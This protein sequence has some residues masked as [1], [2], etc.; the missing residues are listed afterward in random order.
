MNTSKS[1]YCIFLLLVLTIA[2][3]PA[4]SF[5]TR[6]D[7]SRPQIPL[8]ASNYHQPGSGLQNSRIRFE[9]Y[10][11]G[12]V[13]FL[14]GSITY[15]G[16][17]RDSLMAYFQRRFPETEFEFIGAGIPSMGSTPSAFRLQ[18]DVLSKGRVDLLFVEAAVND[19]T[20]GR[21]SEEQ[22]RAMEGI[23]RHLKRSNEAIDVVMMHFVDPGKIE[24]YNENREP[25]VIT[26]HNQVARYYDLPVINLAKEVTD[27]INN[28]EFTWEDDFKNLHPS[29]F[30]QGIYAHS[31]M[32]MLENAYSGDL[33]A[34]DKITAPPLPV[35]L[36]AYCYDNG[37]LIDIATIKLKKGW[38]VDPSWEPDDGTSTRANYTRVPMLISQTP[39]ST[40]SISFKGNAVGI[41]VAAGQDAG[42]IEF[43][44]DKGNWQLQNLFTRWSEHLHLPWY[45]TLAS[46]LPP[47]D[48]QLE[49]RI[50]EQKHERSS[51]HACRIRYFFVNG[52]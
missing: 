28:S 22:V 47:G 44:I 21:T 31:M 20:N 24:D 19:D 38:E 17:W 48:H 4:Q 46:G 7:Q 52:N 41:A 2:P 42:T 18:R 50:S 37:V 16:G 34:D 29:P 35:K 25:Q 39:G 5:N 30:G 23:I 26:N 43:R 13:A 1:W 36:D 11:Q 51:G 45:Y 40:I 3:V 10:K 6:V 9:Q 12:R 8:D 15:N 49:L 33:D 27:R 32:V 14:G